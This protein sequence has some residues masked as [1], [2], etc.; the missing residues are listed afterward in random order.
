MVTANECC[1]LMCSCNVYQIPFLITQP[2]HDNRIPHLQMYSVDTMMAFPPLVSLEPPSSNVLLETGRLD[3]YDRHG[4][5]FTSKL[6][7][8][9][10]HKKTPANGPLQ[11]E[12][13]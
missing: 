10:H 4:R 1:S 5:L 7:L 8:M 2:K 13:L 9:F 6:G 11:L 12:P 3:E